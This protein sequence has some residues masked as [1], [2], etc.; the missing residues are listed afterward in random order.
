MRVTIEPALGALLLLSASSL[1]GQG[2][3]R[4]RTTT[5]PYAN[6]GSDINRLDMIRVQPATPDRITP[7]GV[8]VSVHDLTVPSKAAKELERA[9]K[10]FK[11]GDFRSAAEHLQKA[12]QIA[13]GFVQAHNNL[14]ATYIRL[15]EYEL[16]IVQLQEAVELAP[17]L[18]E[19]YYHLGI[20]LLLLGRLPEA[21]IAAR[22]ALDIG[23]PDSSARFTLGR[24]LTVEEKN[25]PEAMHLLYESAPDIP[26]ARLSLAQVLQRR[27]S[28]E[29]AIA[30]LQTYL[31]IPDATNK[32]QVG[33]W[34]ALWTKQ[35]AET[36]TSAPT[37]QP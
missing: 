5:N 30:E 8:I 7:S 31:R 19:P 34:V 10:S 25:T 29:Q 6:S 33:A 9:M 21:E 36:R 2:A 11:A 18:R 20:A 17:N 22:R 24:I 14:G 28:L 4:F 3:D 32:E 15:H 12:L 1:H 37:Q 27:G 23:P 13:P 26:E 35:L 16:A